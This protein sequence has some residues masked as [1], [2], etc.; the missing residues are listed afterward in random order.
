MDFSLIQISREKKC[1]MERKTESEKQRKKDGER[2]RGELE[3]EEEK[4]NL[5]VRERKRKECFL[6][7]GIEIKFP[8]PKKP[9]M[10]KKQNWSK[11]P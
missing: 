6:A 10:S 8:S 11:F 5:K 1:S 9:L 7:D 2:E 4:D 3:T